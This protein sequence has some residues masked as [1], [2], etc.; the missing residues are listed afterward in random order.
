MPI[1]KKLKNLNAEIEEL[2][3]KV[4]K[5]SLSEVY[6]ALSAPGRAFLF[7]NILVL[8]SVRRFHSGFSSQNK[9]GM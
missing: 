3:A 9:D 4:D 7:P 5:M 2:E 6:N 1:K 8:L